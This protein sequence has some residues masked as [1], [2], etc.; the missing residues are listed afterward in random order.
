MSQYIKKHVRIMLGLSIA[1]ALMLSARFASA[2][3]ST[4]VG[5]P[6]S[7]PLDPN[8]YGGD[9]AAAPTSS[10]SIEPGAN[11]LLAPEDRQLPYD[12]IGASIVA[13]RMNPSVT[14]MYSQLLSRTPYQ[15]DNTVWDATHLT[16]L[17]QTLPI[18]ITDITNRSSGNL[19]SPALASSFSPA[20]GNALSEVSKNLS[21]KG[22]QQSFWRVGASTAAL[23]ANSLP[24][25]NSL[26]QS[27]FPIGS[28]NPSGES[29][30]QSAL[31][32]GASTAALTI[33]SPSLSQETGQQPGRTL[34]LNKDALKGLN[35]GNGHILTDK[36]L[37]QS[38]QTGSGSQSMTKA[39]DYSRSPLEVPSREDQ[40]AIT[41]EAASPFESLDQNNFLNPDINL[42]SPPRH[43]SRRAEAILSKM[44][45]SSESRAASEFSRKEWSEL[46]PTAGLAMNRN[47]LSDRTRVMKHHDLSPDQTRIMKLSSRT[48]A[49]TKP[50][51]HN[52]ILQQMETGVTS[53]RQ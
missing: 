53:D 39:L 49:V 13:T 2:Q 40:S 32:T 47:L 43:L 37:T 10:K 22:S 38:Q 34:V 29:S 26:P 14:Q 23:T 30:Q 20:L 36:G 5:S 7:Q 9:T 31:R 33:N 27:A 51:W 42:A 21:E 8:M 28:D 4:S 19:A 41:V 15:V 52:P 48:T 11:N 44:G 12:S 24:L 35:K 45:I 50:K 18:N 17:H 3:L 6:L 25:S 1:A 16:G 46:Q